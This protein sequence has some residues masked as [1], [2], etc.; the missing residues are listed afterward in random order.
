MQTFLV[1]L[2]QYLYK[3]SVADSCRLFNHIPRDSFPVA[4]SIESYLTCAGQDWDNLADTKPRNTANVLSHW[5]RV[6]HICVGKLTNFVSDNGLLSGRRQ[7]H[8]LNQCWNIVNWT[9][10]E[11]LQ[12]NLI[13]IIEENALKMSSTKWRPF[14]L[15]LNVLNKRNMSTALCV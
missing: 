13:G 15:S 8:Y 9:L 10:R 4:M 6:T 1:V 3:H 11:N 2:A 5:G 7:G 12:W 14:C